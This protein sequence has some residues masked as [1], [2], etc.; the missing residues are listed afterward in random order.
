MAGLRRRGLVVDA[1]LSDREVRGSSP[2]FGSRRLVLEKGY[3]HTYLR[4]THALNEY[5]TMGSER[6]CLNAR[7]MRLTSCSS[8]LR[9]WSRADGLCMAHTP[10][11]RPYEPGAGLMVS[12]W[13]MHQLQDLMTGT[14]TDSLCMAHAPTSRPYE[15]G[16]GLIASVWLIHQL[17][18]LTNREQG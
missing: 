10:T 7:V 5:P 17:Q 18:D 2:A 15:P 14:R 16:A 3:L 9:T 8:T 1:R 12:V 6:S 11:S 13:L 4:L